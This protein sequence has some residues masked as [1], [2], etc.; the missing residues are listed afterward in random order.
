MVVLRPFQAKAVEEIREAF[1][2]GWRN[3]LYVAPTGAGKTIL[4][5]YIVQHAV[6]L[7]TRVLILVHRVELLEQVCESLTLLSVP[8]GVIGDGVVCISEQVTVGVVDSV[9]LHLR[10]LQPFDLVIVDEAQHCIPRNKWGR[11]LNVLGLHARVLGVTATPQRLDGAGLGDV[12]QHMIVGPSEREL[13]ESE[14]PYLV[15]PLVYAPPSGVD[16]TGVATIGGDYARDEQAEI[17]DRPTITGCAIEHY[18]RICPGVPA[19]VF[20]TRITHAENV[21]AQAR[22]AGIRAEVIHGG[23]SKSRRRSLVA[24][25][26]D[27]EIDWLAS[28]DLISEGFNCPAIGAAILL[29]ATKSLSVFR[30]T[31][32]RALRVDGGKQFAYILD[33]VGNVFVHGMPDRKIEWT[34]EGRKRRGRSKEATVPVMQCPDCFAAFAPAKQCPACGARMKVKEATIGQVQG[35]LE[36][37]TAEELAAKREERAKR[38]GRAKTLDELYQLA[39]ELRTK[40]GRPYKPEWADEIYKSRHGY[41]AWK[42]EKERISNRKPTPPG[43]ERVV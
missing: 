7:G 37:V 27:G 38:I 13:I 1:L 8:F 4:F 26:R 31:V 17:M 29:R 21:A 2:A 22:G 3:V 23:L 18:K 19:V 10:K 42:T 35:S 11:V 9:S 12:F 24:R 28:V 34:L 32:G 15:P 33:H 43:F 41:G 16:L 36:R 20:C 14:P 6:A 5:S 25:F 40:D 39:S 30:Q